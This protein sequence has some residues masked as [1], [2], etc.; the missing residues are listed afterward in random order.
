MGDIIF[1]A[2][3]AL[4]TFAGVK[5]GFAR[6]FISITST[7]ASMLCGF[8]LYK[9]VSAVIINSG[10]GKIISENIGEMIE[11][12]MNSHENPAAL[13][14]GMPNAKEAVTA[15]T[16]NAISFIIAMIV[17]KIII[18]VAATVLNLA[19]KLPLVKQ[20]NG[21]LGGAFGLFSGIVICY[22]TAGLSSMLCVNESF[23]WL[24]DAVEGSV[25]FS[26]LGNGNIVTNVL[27]EF[28]KRK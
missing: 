4:C 26:I 12:S 28:M 16:A 15:L 8:F 25:L 6:S 9:P 10:I 2:I 27:S 20:L 1:I 17:I 7:V 11:K 21:L 13:I 18:M 24:T 5:R 3:I 22:I 19:V 23:M 14:L